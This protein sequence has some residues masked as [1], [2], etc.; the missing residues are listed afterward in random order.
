MI[1]FYVKQLGRHTKKLLKKKDA[2]YLSEMR[3][4]MRNISNEL[5]RGID[6]ARDFAF[7]PLVSSGA[8]QRAKHGVAPYMFWDYGSYVNLIAESIRN[9]ADKR[10]GQIMRWP[11]RVDQFT[12]END[13]WD[14]EAETALLNKWADVLS[15]TDSELT[16]EPYYQEYYDHIGQWVSIPTQWD[17]DGDPTLYRMEFPEDTEEMK[18]IRDDIRQHENAI[19]A[20]QRDIL[21]ELA[22]NFRYL[23]D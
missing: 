18:K 5:S 9:F 7:L 23:W 16:E 10:H 1:D 17:K 3:I 20:L 19:Y 21:V 22:D 8:R 2:R 14:F 12:K 11:G 13:G 15:I 6:A 4:D